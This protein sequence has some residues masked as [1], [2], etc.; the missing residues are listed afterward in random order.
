M[1]T[2]STTTAGCLV[3]LLRAA[4]LLF[5]IEHGFGERIDAR[6]G[7]WPAVVAALH[8]YLQRP[9]LRPLPRAEHYWLKRSP[10]LPHHCR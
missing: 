3:Y 2:S 7:P 8:F 10:S 9:L 6:L 5:C 1:S 4:A